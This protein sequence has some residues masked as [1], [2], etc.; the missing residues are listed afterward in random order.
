[1]RPT[2]ARACARVCATRVR[3]VRVRPSISWRFV[4]V[5]VFRCRFSVI[6][7]TMAANTYATVP[8]TCRIVT[9]SVEHLQEQPGTTGT[10][11]PIFGAVGTQTGTN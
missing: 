8:L 3:R 10:N 6:Q 1:M 4:P 2:R 5:Y 7:R 9:E 11:T